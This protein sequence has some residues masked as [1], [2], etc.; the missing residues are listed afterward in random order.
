MLSINHEKEKIFS[1]DFDL[2]LRR[3]L[4]RSMPSHK[5]PR[6][7]HQPEKDILTKNEHH[8][9]MKSSLESF[10]VTFH[11]FMNIVGKISVSYNLGC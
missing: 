1:R 11:I 10:S 4:R 9:F 8:A 7:V 6:R 2:D 3:K 5:D